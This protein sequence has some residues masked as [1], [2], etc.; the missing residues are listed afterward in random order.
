MPEGER[1]QVFERFARLQEGR[2]RDKGGTGLGLS[3]TKRIVE[4]HGGSIRVDSSDTG[5]ALFVVSLPATGAA[6]WPDQ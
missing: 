4:S 2:E 5:G 6:G 3:L 1:L